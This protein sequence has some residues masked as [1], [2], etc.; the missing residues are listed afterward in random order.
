MATKRKQS[1]G[2]LYL[3]VENEDWVAIYGTRGELEKLGQAL[4]EFARAAGADE[5]CRVQDPVAPVFRPGSLG[6]IFYRR[7]TGWSGAV[8]P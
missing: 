2:D 4:I 8:S 6:Y 1:D 7:K 3:T 5:D